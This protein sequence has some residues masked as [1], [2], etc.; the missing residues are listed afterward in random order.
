MLIVQGYG[1]LG[2]ESAR[3]LKAM[4]MK[5][6]ACNTSGK[7][8]PQDGVSLAASRNRPPSSALLSSLSSPPSRWE[9]GADPQYII[10]G[11]GDPTGSLPSSF[12]STRDPTS[13]DAFLS[14]C[15]LLVASLPGTQGT[16]YLLDAA[17]LGLMKDEAV[18]VNVGRGSLIKSGMSAPALKLYLPRSLFIHSMS[19]SSC[20]IPASLLLM[21]SLIIGRAEH[22]YPTVG[23]DLKLTSPQ[24]NSSKP[25][26]RP[27]SS[28]PRWT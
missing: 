17:K 18:F 1:A 24:K 19:L 8:T 22:Q 27:D 26:T 3:L 28:A 2:R 9:L 16:R 20:S 6:I 15:D 13:L 5:I 10:P 14:E 23:S 7:Q 21:G 4:G 11:T 12:Y 25:S